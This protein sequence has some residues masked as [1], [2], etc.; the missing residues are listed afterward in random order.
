MYRVEL[1][2]IKIEA[3]FNNDEETGERV[4]RYAE[5]AVIELLYSCVTNFSGGSAREVIERGMVLRKLLTAFETQA[6][7]VDL[8]NAE[9]SIVRAAV[10]T[11]VGKLFRVGV[12]LA[13]YLDSF[14]QLQSLAVS[15]G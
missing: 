5:L 12:H 15:P 8:E 4:V 11:N 2:I 14:Y 9:F 7:V 3:G 1:P 6:S 13:D 10:D